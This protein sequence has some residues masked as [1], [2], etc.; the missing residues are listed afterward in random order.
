ME[1]AQ[2][3]HMLPLAVLILLLLH[4]SIAGCIARSKLR[5]AHEHLV[6]YSEVELVSYL[7][8]HQPL[9]FPSQTSVKRSIRHGCLYLNDQPVPRTE[10]VLLSHG[11][12]IQ[13]YERD[14]STRP[15]IQIPSTVQHHLLSILYE[16]DFCAV[17]VKPFNMPMFSLGNAS[18]DPSIAA[19]LH[20]CLLHSLTPA[21][22]SAPSPLRRP[23]SVHRLDTLTGGA[24]V[25]AKT[26]PALR[27]LSESFSRREADKR[28]LAVAAGRLEGEGD[29]LVP[30]GG[31]EAHSR[32]RVLQNDP[33]KSFGWISS[34]EVRLFTGRTHQIR[35]HL[36]GLGHPIVGDPRHWF[37]ASPHLAM[38]SNHV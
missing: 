36:D 22:A 2:L 25:V 17:V 11:D 9:M 8:Q 1:S 32:Y 24:V 26:L 21:P 20:T 4:L 38:P 7:L 10:K 6:Q 3:D 28:Y 16:D 19:S 18:S 30:I 13:L 14:W 35:R 33:S 15:P 5:L 34:V 31:L 27:A 23:Q 12:V 37:R 29:V